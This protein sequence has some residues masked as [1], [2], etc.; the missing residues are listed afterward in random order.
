MCGL[1]RAF[2]RK[3]TPLLASWP[4]LQQSSVG[5][6]EGEMAATGRHEVSVVTVLWEGELSV[7]VATIG[8]WECRD[9][10]LGGRYQFEPRPYYL[11]RDCRV[12]FSNLI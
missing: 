2:R 4:G 1:G 8:E 9:P 7:F 3:N 5:K 11:M 10:G 6:E 12:N